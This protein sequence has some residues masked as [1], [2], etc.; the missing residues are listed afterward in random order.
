M[1]NVWIASKASRSDLVL[2]EKIRER[3]F[4]GPVW[5]PLLSF[6]RCGREEC[7]LLQHDGKRQ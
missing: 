4:F 5:W 1:V 2:Q 7:I 6:L 3:E